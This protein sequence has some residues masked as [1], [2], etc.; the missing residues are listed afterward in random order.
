[1]SGTSL[2][3]VD[4]VCCEI[5]RETCTLLYA[6]EYAFPL[7]LKAKILG[8]IDSHSSLKNLGEIDH[9]LGI[10]FAHCVLDFLKI[11]SLNHR[12]IRAIGLHGQTLWHNPQGAFPFSMQGGDANILTALSGIEVIA[13]FRRKDIALGGQGAPFAP[14]FHA[15]LFGSL[16]QNIAL[17]NIGGMANISVLGAKLIG[18]DT[19]CGN[20]LLDLWIAQHLQQSYDKDGKWAREGTLN[21]VL[22]K[23]F[24]ADSYFT[25]P[26]PKSTGRERFNRHWLASFALEK[27]RPQDV[28][29]TLLE[30]TAQSIALE[31][32]HFALDKLLLC[33]GGAK[34]TFLCERLADLLPLLCI[35]IAP[36]A[37]EMEAMTFA[38]L[39][40][41]RIHK[42]PVH[43]KEV[44][45]ARE[46]TILG[47]SYV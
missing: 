23:A 6:K 3:G 42:E 12:E 39:A 15:F 21:Q 29:A 31:V 22:L 24:L 33:G 10:V 40:Y 30:L 17:V 26:Y 8:A 27:Y 14:A 4:V 35:E 13:D 43:L 38:W 18:Y 47:A 34:N 45:G 41:K 5:D 28:Q 32:K 44:T 7:D 25:K 2:D 19:G 9:A 11:F 36:F 1:M 46:N 16:S 20:V 37:D